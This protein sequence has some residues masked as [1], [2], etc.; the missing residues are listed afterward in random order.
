M[1]RNSRLKGSVS[2]VTMEL[3]IGL[4]ML[5]WYNRIA[6]IGFGVPVGLEWE[7]VEIERLQEWGSKWGLK[8]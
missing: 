8:F 2:R 5:E 3:V 4:G 7:V 6:G 1:A